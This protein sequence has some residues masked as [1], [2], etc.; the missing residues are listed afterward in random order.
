MS[1]NPTNQ[2]KE[3][4]F[5]H[6]LQDMDRKQEEQVRKMKELQSHVERLQGENDRLRTHIGESHEPGRVI[7][8]KAFFKAF[9]INLCNS[10]L[11]KSR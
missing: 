7:I 3:D 9:S 8:N 6:W 1:N 4:Q 10:P 5:L 2:S 11:S